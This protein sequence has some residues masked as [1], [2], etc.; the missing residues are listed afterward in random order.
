MTVIHCV[1]VCA[2][3]HMHAH[4]FGPLQNKNIIF[5]FCGHKVGI[6]NVLYLIIALRIIIIKSLYN[7]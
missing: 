1:R 4:K 6:G 3:M 2:H 7:V 5:N